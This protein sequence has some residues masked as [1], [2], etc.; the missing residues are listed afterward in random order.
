MP[1]YIALR[2]VS[3]AGSVVADNAAAPPAVGY[4]QLVVGAIAGIGAAVLTIWFLVRPGERRKDHIKRRILH[5]DSGGQ[6][7]SGR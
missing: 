7:Q 6:A 1:V 3:A 5:E 4:L 2:A